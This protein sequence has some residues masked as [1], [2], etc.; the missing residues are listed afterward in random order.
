MP[1]AWS[2]RGRSLRWSDPELRKHGHVLTRDRYAGAE[3]QEEDGEPFEDKMNRLAAQW[4]TQQAEAARL[5]AAIEVN[6]TRLGF[7]GNK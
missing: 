4:R 3:I 5:D 6:L 7:G 1:S 2:H